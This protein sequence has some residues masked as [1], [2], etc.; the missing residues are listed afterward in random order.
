MKLIDF[1]GYFAE[2]L[3]LSEAKPNG[4]RYK[5][6]VNHIYDVASRNKSTKPIEILAG[7]CVV[8]LVIAVLAQQAG[9][10]P[11][12]VETAFM[13]ALAL[14]MVAAIAL[15]TRK[16]L[17]VQR[18]ITQYLDILLPR[19]RALPEAEADSALNLLYTEPAYLRKL[20]TESEA[21]CGCIR[22]QALFPAR[23]IPWIDSYRA[24]GQC[25][26][27]GAP[28]EYLVFS[29]DDVEVVAENLALLHTL[30]DEEN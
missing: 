8:L 24:V 12:A 14:C 9:K 16:D 27:C 11:D 26:Q 4:L 10:L 29:D 7:I 18:E 5:S 25:P 30:F 2:I 22:C 3:L 20:P 23:S 13:V 15:S 19:I 6:T 28:K 17:S 1:R 21:P